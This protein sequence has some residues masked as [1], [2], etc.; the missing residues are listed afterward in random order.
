MNWLV[1]LVLIVLAIASVALVGTTDR[2]PPPPSK[3]AEMLEAARE[4]VAD[5][6][7]RILNRLDPST[8]GNAALRRLHIGAAELKAYVRRRH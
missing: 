3:S 8:L 5:E 4:V 1:G 7:A 6:R 2:D